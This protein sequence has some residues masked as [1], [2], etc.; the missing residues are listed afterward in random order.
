[1]WDYFFGWRQFDIKRADTVLEVGSGNRP[2]IRSDVLCDKFPFSSYE[3]S[4]NKSIVVDRPFIAADAIHLPFQDKS[5]D[6]LYCAD[7]AEHLE[8]PH[9]FFNECERVAKKGAIVTPSI[10][11]E[12]L[13]GWEYHAVMYEIR[14]NRLIIHRK[15]KDNWGWFGETFHKLCV[16]DKHFQRNVNRHP[17]LFR[18]IYEWKNKIRYQHVETDV[19]QKNLW[20]RTSSVEQ[21]IVRP[22]GLV[23]SIKRKIKSL[24]SYILRKRLLFRKEIDLKSI[25]CCPACHGELNYESAVDIIECI[26]CKKKYNVRNNIPILILNNY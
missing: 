1:M 11:A 26:S 6:F 16:D 12:R 24:L 10:L 5:I 9:K 3:R 2:L 17:E 22:P 15:T 14:D 23:E 7:L 25:L 4:A 8:E 13:F 19:S 20:K 21:T 18:M